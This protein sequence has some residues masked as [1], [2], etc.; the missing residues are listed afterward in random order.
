M[1]CVVQCGQDRWSQFHSSCGML[2]EESWKMGP[3]GHYV[4]KRRINLPTNPFHHSL[5]SSISI[6]NT[7]TDTSSVSFLL[8]VFGWTALDKYFDDFFLNSNKFSRQPLKWLRR[9]TIHS[10]LTE[11]IFFAYSR[12]SYATATSSTANISPTLGK[13][14]FDYENRKSNEN[15]C[16]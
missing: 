11:V 1:L 4:Y 8:K 13:A 7:T 12:Y 16:R 14:S 5:T 6:M 10:N 3:I 15:P 9:S 2:H